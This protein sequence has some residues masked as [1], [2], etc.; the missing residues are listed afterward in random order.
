MISEKIYGKLIAL[1]REI[2]LQKSSN[3]G[4][5]PSSFLIGNVG[6]EWWY[7]KK[8]YKECNDLSKMIISSNK[9]FVNCDYE[10]FSRVII[11]T[12]QNNGFNKELFNPDLVFKSKIDNLL[13]ASNQSDYKTLSKK[14]YS[15]IENKLQS[16]ITDWM[17]LYPVSSL[18]SDTFVFESLDLVL[19]SSDDKTYWQ[20]FSYDYKSSFGFNP[21]NGQNYAM[22]II[23]A[24]YKVPSTWL[25]F[26]TNG[27]ENGTIRKMKFN[28]KEFIACICSFNITSSESFPNYI[29]NETPRY[30][31]LFPGNNVVDFNLRINSLPFLQ[32]SFASNFEVSVE[33]LK[34]VDSYIK[35]I[36]SLAIES[37]KRF[38][39]ATQ[40]IHYGLLASSD[41]ERFMHFYIA[42]DALFGEKKNVKETIKSGLLTIKDIEPHIEDKADKLFNLRNEILHG[43]SSIIEDSKYYEKYLEKYEINPLADIE[44]ICYKSIKSYVKFVKKI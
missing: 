37:R 26:K 41:I 2:K 28:I 33:T 21:T 24:A 6:L 16:T 29:E 11:N 10:Y 8:S 13:E 17:V 15:I 36:N 34:E 4:C 38:E 20:N 7:T 12:I 42:L 14:L 22:N 25:I 18:K 3:I 35:S 32:P 9:N 39:T 44:L 27:T 43:G 30:C 40:F 19:L 31:I 1:L 5:F 23:P